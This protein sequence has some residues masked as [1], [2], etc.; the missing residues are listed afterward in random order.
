MAKYLDCKSN[1]QKGSIKNNY[2]LYRGTTIYSGLGEM[3]VS[4]KKKVLKKQLNI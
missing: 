4:I 3:E 2:Q 1:Y